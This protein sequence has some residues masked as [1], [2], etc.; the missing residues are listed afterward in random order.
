LSKLR[1]RTATLLI[2]IFMIS[3]FAVAMPVSAYDLGKPEFMVSARGHFTTNFDY[4]GSGTG[5][6]CFINLHAKKVADEWTGQGVFW[7]R[8]YKDGKLVA[9]FTINVATWENLPRQVNFGGTVDVYVDDDFIGN[10][11]WDSILAIGE[12]FEIFSFQIRYQG[13]D[14]HAFESGCPSSDVSVKMTVK[15]LE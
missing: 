8:D 11:V 3:I 9:I 6:R 7:D 2:A 15:V 1:E 14:Y 13:L 5:H 10:Y 4:R 12:P